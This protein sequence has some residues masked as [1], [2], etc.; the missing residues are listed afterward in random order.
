MPIQEEAEL[1]ERLSVTLEEL[2][3]AE[4][5]LRVR[6]DQ[7]A[8][9]YD[10]IAAERQRY[11]DLFNFAPDGYLVT[12]PDGV[13]HE[14]NVAATELLGRPRRDLVGQPV[15]A[16]VHPNARGA[17]GR[18]LGRVRQAGRAKGTEL[19]LDVGGLPVPVLVHVTAAGHPGVGPPALRWIVHNLT[20]LRA[21]QERADRADR[22]VAVG[23]AAVALGHECRTALQRAKACLSMLRLEAADRPKALDLVER[24]NRAVDDLTRLVEDVRIAVSRPNL[25]CEPCDLRG[26]WRAAWEQT[27]GADAA[28]LTFDQAGAGPALTADPFRLRQ[29]FANLFGNALAAGARRVT[30]AVAEAEL[31]DRPAWRI[32][33]RDDGPGLSAEQRRRMFEPFYTTRPN[34]TGLG[35]TIVQSIVEAH[36]GAVA[37][38]EVPA[39]TEVVITLPRDLS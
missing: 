19:L 24:T 8:S 28:G 36:S 16:F 32:S 18:V 26:V 1:G 33:V 9:A 39:G 22:L 38:A 35:M 34:G 11:H 15:R 37:A 7:L 4:E 12:D 2:R 3:A 20:D 10:V 17:L 13:I 27:P 25:R 29:V 23:Q 14:A 21:A 6:N 30:V 31:Q 5:Q